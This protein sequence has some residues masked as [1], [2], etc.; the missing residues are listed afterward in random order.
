[1]LGCGR[2][3]GARTHVVPKQLHDEGGDATVDADEDVDAGENHVG[4]AGDGE[5]EG[6][7]VHERRDGPPEG[8]QTHV[9]RV[10]GGVVIFSLLF[11]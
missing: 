3:P 8:P 7:R 2:T 9:S 4:R 11:R 1:M 5:E 10:C 6:G